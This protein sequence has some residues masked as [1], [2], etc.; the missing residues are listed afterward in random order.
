MGSI[1]RGL[2]RL[3]PSS[4]Q[5]FPNNIR[6]KNQ[7]NTIKKAEKKGNGCVIFTEEPKINHKKTKRKPT[8]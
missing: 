4:Y 8:R 3:D 2:K 1:E 7:V 6:E 5:T